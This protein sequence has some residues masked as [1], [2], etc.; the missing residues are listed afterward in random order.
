[1]R[2]KFSILLLLPALLF[3]NA[4]QNAI[5]KAPPYAT[6]KLQN[7]VYKGNIYINKPLTIVGIGESVVLE[8]SGKGSVVTIR[9]SHVVLRHL[10]IT[11]SG[12]NMQQIDAGISMQGV[13]EC[14]IS[15]CKL[16]HVL[17]GIDMDRVQESLIAK[18]YIT[19]YKN[20]LPL[21]ANGLKLYYAHHNKILHNKIE[22]VRDVTLNY[23]HYNLFEENE[24]IGNR[25]AT[26]LSL[27]NH[28]KFFKNR[29]RYNSVSMMF[30]GA[31]DTKVVGNT[32]VSSNGAAGIGVM[33]GSV[34]AFYFHNN[35]LSFNAKGI[36]IQGQEKAKGM[37]RYITGNELSYNGEAIHFHASI[38]DN[39]ITKN[40][41]FSNI[42]DVVKDAGKNFESSNV[43][44]Y[45][46]WDRYAGFDRDNDGIG[47]QPFSIYQYADQLWQYNHK[48]KFFY[49][50]PLMTLLNFLSQLAP[51]IE[52]NLI[53]KDSKPLINISEL[54]ARLP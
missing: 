26:H 49:A 34:S 47:D 51:F 38:K 54:N 30:M 31:Q 1:M 11:K 17:Y 44:A 24:F 29:Y 14:E 43:V 46:Y 16:S 48:V 22:N 41:I 21:R 2:K 50:S 12:E 13:K 52:P 28:N 20:D 23:S 8:G 32:I 15:N 4:L 10:T 5:D 25:F 37:K 27:S 36:Y 6:I 7:A 39:T 35:R 42:N 33:I 53:M 19:T 45:N 40:A 9:S 3:G 18:N